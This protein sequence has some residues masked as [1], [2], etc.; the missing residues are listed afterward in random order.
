MGHIFLHVATSKRM[1]LYIIKYESTTLVLIFLEIYLLLVGKVFERGKK[2][3]K[4]KSK[5]NAIF[6]TCVHIHMI[7]NVVTVYVYIL[8]I[9]TYGNCFI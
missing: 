3:G 8:V 9:F 6:G 7:C 2:N 1:F 5:N 4:K